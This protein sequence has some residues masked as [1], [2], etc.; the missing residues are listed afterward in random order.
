MVIDASWRPTTHTEFDVGAVGLSIAFVHVGD[1]RFSIFDDASERVLTLLH[2]RPNGEWRTMTATY[3][4]HGHRGMGVAA[5]M[6]V[7]I[8]EAADSGALTQRASAGGTQV[9]L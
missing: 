9:F 6:G 3:P 7:V 2:M 1:D 5:L 4:V 8:R